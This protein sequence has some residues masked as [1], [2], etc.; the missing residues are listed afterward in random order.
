MRCPPEA[1]PDASKLG[2]RTW[3]GVY[4]HTNASAGVFDCRL[5]YDLANG[6]AVAPL[7]WVWY[8]GAHTNGGQSDPITL[9]NVYNLSPEIYTL[10]LTV[11][12][13]EVSKGIGVSPP[14]L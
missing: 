1:C 11:Q 13:A 3:F 6:T 12:P 10:V 5:Q 2:D 9:C 7:P 4:G 14:R 8:D